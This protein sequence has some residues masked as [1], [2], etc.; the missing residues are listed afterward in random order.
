MVLPS[1]RHQVPLGSNGMGMETSE[2][3]YGGEGHL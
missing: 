3:G 1:L 2:G